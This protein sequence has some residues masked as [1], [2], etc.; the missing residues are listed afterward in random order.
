MKKKNYIIATA[1]HVDHGKT[2]LIKALT[3]KDCDTHLEEKKRGITIHLGFSHIMLA[4]DTYAGIVDVPGHEDFVDTMI[5]G[6]NGIDL[7]LFI[8]ESVDGF[9]KQTF[10]HLEILQSLKVKKG[11]I[12]MTKCDMASIETLSKNI[13][14]AKEF[15]IGT[16]LENAPIVTVSAHKNHNIKK[17][18]RIIYQELKGVRRDLYP[19]KQSN[20]I[21][22]SK[23]KKEIQEFDSFRM[24]PDRFFSV[25]GFGTVVT[26]TVLKGKI[27]KNTPLY[28][29]TLE[30]ELKI[31]KLEAYGKEVNEI[32]SG[33][34]ASLNISNL[35][36]TEFEK[37]QMLCNQRYDVTT[38]IDVELHLFH[39]GIKY[40][41]LWS[42]AV[43]FSGT[44]KSKVKIHLIDSSTLEPNKKCFAQL[45]FT[46]PITISYGDKYIIR[47][48]CGRQTIGS[49]WV[50]D[51][52][53]LHH[54]RRTKITNHRNNNLQ[55]KPPSKTKR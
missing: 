49:G 23:H 15:T 17:L 48:T 40:L 19:P 1:G 47:S 44:I 46:K 43:F 14:D 32:S 30:K 42:E 29:P 10:E 28:I 7:V 12:V 33:Q 34:R 54:K 3:G 27:T 39:H 52:F 25:K 5:S 8:V 21:K 26:G 35:A 4:N 38:M 11:I 6:I 50:I 37:G 13:N 53:P 22:K 24:Y 45:H 20:K 9:M 36:L 2:S 18:K 41:G 51:P 31:R 55:H 16:F